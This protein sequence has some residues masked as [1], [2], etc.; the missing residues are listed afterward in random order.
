MVINSGLQNNAWSAL[1]ANIFCLAIQW[2]SDGDVTTR[3]SY[4]SLGLLGLNVLGHIFGILGPMP[5]LY[6]FTT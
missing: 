3:N 4:N 1:S 2:R 5:R 6:L